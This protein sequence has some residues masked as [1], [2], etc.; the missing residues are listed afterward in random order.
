MM[1]KKSPVYV[2][3][4]NGM[5]GSA[6]VRRLVEEGFEQI[7]TR[8]SS[9]L[10]LRRQHD[11]EVFFNEVRP[12][13]VFVAAARVGGIHAN[14][15]YRAEFIYDNLAIELN[16]INSAWRTGVKNLIFLSSSCV[17]PRMA[18]QPMS[19]DM[20]WTGKPEPTNEPYAVAKLAGMSLCQAYNDQYGTRYLSML[21]TNLYGKNDDYGPENSHVIAA[22]INK[23][24]RG[25]VEQQ[26]SVSIWGTG[27]PRREFLHVDDA[28]DAIFFLLDRYENTAPIN[29]GCGCDVDIAT[30][31]KMIGD[32]VGYEGEIQYDTSKQD[33]APRKLLDSSQLTQLGWK[34]SISLEDGLKFAY[35]D[36]MENL[37]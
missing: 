18:A 32:I 24:H 31:A 30:L 4:H 10:D 1:D 9:E 27:T 5:V 23:F 3:G 20:L 17:Y 6:L 22:L 15:T 35:Q 34:P 14:N 26:P 25:K 37:R 36:F 13:T 8:S 11:V 19:E 12:E 28:V 2:A 29:I 16:L 21:P 33:G 7:I